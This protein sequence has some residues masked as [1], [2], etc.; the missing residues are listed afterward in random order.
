MNIYIDGHSDT[1]TEIYDQKSE[2]NNKKFCFNTEDAK[3]YVPI[4]QTLATFVRPTYED[5][6]K[7]ANEVLD[8]FLE[9]NKDIKIIKSKEDLDDVIQ[10]KKVGGL[11]SIENG[12][13]IEN[14]LNNIDILYNKGIRMM[15]IN[16]NEDNLLGTGAKTKENY[17]LTEF[18][19]QYVKRLE[20]KNIIIDVSHSSEKT[21]WD[22][23]DNTKGIIVATHSNCYNLCDHPR[24]LKDE[25]IKA[26]AERNGIIG[27]CLCNF[28]LKNKG[29]TNVED[30][31]RHIDYII[32]LVGEDYV[33]LGTDFDGVEE[34]YRLLDIKRLSDMK[35]LEKALQEHGYK[36]ETI[37]K[38][39]GEN[40]LRVIK[41][42][43]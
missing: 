37:N 30:L 21:F 28:F 11:L 33:G 2:I 25:Q 24:N 3:E 8:Y 42:K 34:E 35:I 32:N 4:I 39:M 19:I 29:T 5:G 6:F 43:I 20:E 26:I 17:G 40:W 15:S 9:N 14:D 31:I 7:R 1:L 27:I 38:I 41:N 18:G 23:I 10:N 36:E 12:R 13:A 16:W 22:V